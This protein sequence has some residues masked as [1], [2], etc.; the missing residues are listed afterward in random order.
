MDKVKMEAIFSDSARGMKP[1]P[2][3]E[4]M[5]YIKKPGVISFAGGNPDPNIFPVAEF[6]EGASVI[7]KNGADVLQYGA[8]DGY[9]PLKTFIANWMAPRM[10]RVTAPDEIL[11][12]TGSQQG[13]DLL[14]STLINPGDYIIVEDPTYPGAIHTMR[15]RG[16]NFLT[17][18]CDSDGMKVGLLPEIIENCQNSGGAVKFI[19]CIVNFQNPSG[20]TLSTERRRQLLQ[21][22]GKYDLIVFEDDPYGHLRY[23]GV[24]KPAM[25]SMDADERVIYACSFSK[26]L[27]PGARVAWIVGHRDIINKM[28]MIKQ[29]IDLCTSVV[30]QALV[31]QYCLD[32]YLDGFLPRIVDHYR[33]KRDGMAAAFKKYLP[34]F[35]EYDVPEGGFFF[36]LRLPGVDTRKLFEKAVERGVAFVHGRAFYANE[37]GGEDRLRACFTF[38]KEEELEE[39]ARR[40]R[41]AIMDLS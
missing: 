14:C 16:A 2:I 28:V 31:A 9:E 7:R 15:N 21:I 41:D 39:G 10:G 12:S 29:G 19:Y 35:V 27:A 4:L 37:G 22:A 5:P 11:I 18:P 17:V 32:G 33:K 8:T 13:T 36:W 34:S 25:F 6:A 3:R 20:C 24:H 1:S 40:L 30:A 23:D 26:I 38:A